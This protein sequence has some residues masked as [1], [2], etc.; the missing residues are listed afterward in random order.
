MHRRQF[1]QY[2]VATGAGLT[3]AAPAL[4][5]SGQ[6]IRIIYPFGVGSAGDGLGR[7]MA[8]ALRQATGKTIVFENRTG[9]EGKIGT[10]AVIAA[11]PDGNTILFTPFAPIVIHP[12]A[13][14]DLGYDPFTALQPVTQV[15][16]FEFAMS[17]SLTVPAETLKDTMAWLR[18]NPDRAS[19]GVT[20]STGLP[21]FTA[22]LVSSMERVDAKPV[23]YRS[24][25]QVLS[26]IIGGHIPLA[27]SPASEVGEMYRTRK[28]RVLAT[29]GPQRSRA[30]PDVPTYKE[31]GYDVVADAWYALYVPAGT[32]AEIVK[33]Y[34]RIF[35]AAIQGGE[36]RDLIERLEMEPAGTTPEGL[37]EIQREAF[38]RWSGPIKRFQT[39]ETK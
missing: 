18:A 1:L 7:L 23:V 30:L 38:Q 31:L 20:G 6:T 14:D 29:S 32:P 28:L 10:R 22:K 4:A 27:S 24:A 3:L 25:A 16:R 5:Q 36:G 17:S 39:V 15:S 12:A 35:V 11:P 33:E 37:G 2:A 21:F 8:D 9:A 13:F 26:D 34:N 19:F